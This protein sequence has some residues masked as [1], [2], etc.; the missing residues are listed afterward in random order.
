M[1]SL[2]SLENVGKVGIERNGRALNDFYIVKKVRFVIFQLNHLYLGLEIGLNFFTKW[3][4]K[5]L[6]VLLITKMLIWKT[7]NPKVPPTPMNACPGYT[8]HCERQ[9]HLGLKGGTAS[10]ATNFET[11]AIFA[12]RLTL[13]FF[14]NEMLRSEHHINLIQSIHNWC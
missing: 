4:L 5:Q 8:A 2:R 13:V 14:F 3:K 7:W 1:L 11:P 9:M 12:C 6:G 10:S